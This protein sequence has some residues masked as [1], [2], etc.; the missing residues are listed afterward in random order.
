MSHPTTRVLEVLE[1]LHAHGRMRGEELAARLGVDVRTI[2]R[3]VTIL[4]EVGLPLEMERGRYGGYHLRPGFRMPLALTER[5]ALAIAVGLL[6]T[7]QPQQT[8][9]AGE[10]AQ[11]L[12]KLAR[13][14]PAPMRD[15]VRNIEQVVTFAS[16][17]DA[18]DD[19][20]AVE[21]LKTVVHATR[22]CQQIRLRYKAWSGEATSRVVDPYQVVYR[23]GRWYLVGY[24]HLRACQRVF[25]IDHILTA[26]ALPETF[27]PPQVDALAA[28]EQAIGRIP[29]R[30]EYQVRLELPLA[31]ARQRIAATIADLEQQEQ[32]VLMRGFA[33]ELLWLAHLLAGLR[34]HLV[35]LRPPEL[36]AELLALANHVRAI[37]AEPSATSSEA[38]E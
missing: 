21:H 26:T 3:Y 38:K 1:L 17:I 2:R 8:P 25:R 30:W 18:G 19:P 32:G 33:D 31:E 23:Y 11:A 6:S 35:V 16:P 15:M 22:S 36:R 12:A 37:A 29:W 20:G 27:D 13:V 34:C 9:I 28:V 14:L 4:R 24:C 7:R 5:E 10:S